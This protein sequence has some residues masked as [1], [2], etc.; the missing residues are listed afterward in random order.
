MNKEILIFTIFVM[1]AIIMLL[2]VII[3]IYSKGRDVFM[4]TNQTTVARETALKLY[5]EVFDL[6]EQIAKE[7]YLTELAKI[8]KHLGLTILTLDFDDFF[9]EDPELIEYFG[10]NQVSGFLIRDSKTI[11]VNQKDSFV[12]QRFTIAHE[13]GHYVLEKETRDSK[14]ISCRDANSST[15]NDKFEVAANA[16]AAEL[17][18]PE[19]LVKEFIIKAGISVKTAAIIFGVSEQTMKIRLRKL[20]IIV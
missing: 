13:I 11:I 17:L 3:K 18:L 12:R 14:S 7:Q 19:K 9:R 6:D 8:T 2:Y 15:G 16:F 1:F 10:T 5:E 4:M 20:E